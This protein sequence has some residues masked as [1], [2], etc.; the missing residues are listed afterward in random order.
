MP[1]L[2]TTPKGTGDLAGA[3]G[4]DRLKRS[5]A[6]GIF[7]LE[8]NAA[9]V[10]TI[11]RGA[12]KIVVGNLKR[13]WIEDQIYPETFLT[14]AASNTTTNAEMS[15]SAIAAQIHVGD[16]LYDPADN[17]SARV[18]AVSGTSVTTTTKASAWNNS[19]DILRLGNA[20]TQ[21]SDT[22]SLKQTVETVYTN[23]LQR[24]RK[25]FSI[26]IEAQHSDM[27]GEE[28]MQLEK[29]EKLLELLREIEY[30]NLLSEAAVA[31]TQVQGGTGTVAEGIYGFI[32][33]A[34]TPAALKVDQAG[35]ALTEAELNTFVRNTFINR[36]DAQGNN[37][38]LVAAP[39]IIE[40]IQGFSSVSGA[41]RFSATD[42]LFGVKVMKWQT[43]FGEV[44]VVPHPMLATRGTTNT[45][46]NFAFL[47]DMSNIA[48]CVQQ[49]LDLQY[50]QIDKK[51]TTGTEVIEG[52]WSI[53]QCIQIKGS[54]GLHG[55]MKNVLD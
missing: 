46:K 30:T 26:T 35:S 11:A 40:D 24:F 31:G 23:Y 51:Q 27:Y 47:L 54:L 21:G 22:P 19:T 50:T 14:A 25:P 28:E 5:V 1:T 10:T 48:Q 41:M 38:L 13:E 49:G 53:S 2:V 45:N 6:D 43:S 42:N 15:T 52:E 39:A 36:G 33:N 8:A 34:D 16:V 12:R 20:M 32:N 44:N 18:T 17:E 7:L 29:R 4:V 9:P 55:F 37:R 3:L